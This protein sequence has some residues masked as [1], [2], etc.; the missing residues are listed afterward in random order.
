MKLKHTKEEITSIKT[1]LQGLVDNGTDAIKAKEFM[2][3]LV[4]TGTPK[5]RAYFLFRE[6]NRK[7]GSRGMYRTAKLLQVTED[8]IAQ[9]NGEAPVKRVKAPS[10]PKSRIVKKSMLEE[11]TASEASFSFAP[12]YA[13]EA[14]IAEELEL[15]G[16]YL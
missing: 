12:T 9:M 14:D 10:A 8:K 16:T 13:S 11:A 15:M 4:A 5:E 7:H 2:T 6:E 3:S 1:I